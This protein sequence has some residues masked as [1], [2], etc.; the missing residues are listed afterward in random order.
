LPVAWGWAL[1]AINI[2]KPFLMRAFEKLVG[3][4]RYF[5]FSRFA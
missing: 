2:A 4:L 5:G 3:F 1:R